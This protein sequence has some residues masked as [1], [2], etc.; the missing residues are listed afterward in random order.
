MNKMG[1]KGLKNN[2]KRYSSYQGTIG[3]IANNIIQRDFFSDKPNETILEYIRRT[4][5]DSIDV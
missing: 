5:H 4:W 1:L 2:K 3:K